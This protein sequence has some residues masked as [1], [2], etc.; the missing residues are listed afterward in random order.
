MKE[1]K[2]AK[3]EGDIERDRER[4]R[5]CR[6]EKRRGRMGRKLQKKEAVTH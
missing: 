3:R 5:W 1:E 4:E 2:D 6:N